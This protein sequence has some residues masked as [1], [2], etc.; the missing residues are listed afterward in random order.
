MIA[1]TTASSRKTIVVAVVALVLAIGALTIST[2]N[3]V[4]API[5]ATGLTLAKAKT[6]KAI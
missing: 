3:A 6:F 5:Y 2:V 4:T 1:H